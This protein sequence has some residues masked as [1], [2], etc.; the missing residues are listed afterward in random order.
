MLN[1]IM[2]EL[3]YAPIVLLESERTYAANRDK[4]VARLSGTIEDLEDKISS[5]VAEVTRLK[6]ETVVARS[7]ADGDDYARN[8][9]EDCFPGIPVPD[10]LDEVMAKL[11][12]F[13]TAQATEIRDVQQ[14]C[15]SFIEFAGDIKEI[16]NHLRRLSGMP[17]PPLCYP[18]P[19]NP[20]WMQNRVPSLPI[21]DCAA[22][23]P[24]QTE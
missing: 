21:S 5:Y 16:L 2:H 22:T 17:S 23:I 9:F 1:W 7:E 10:K 12:N 19:P 6:R 13:M 15:L 18:L 8:L 14:K 24:T 4:E 20:N 11:H 3:G